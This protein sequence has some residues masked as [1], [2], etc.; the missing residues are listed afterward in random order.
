[1]R[2]DARVTSAA[3]SDPAVTPRDVAEARERIRASVRETP[4]LPSNVIAERAG[5]PVAL[6]LENLQRTGS[7][8]IRGAMN[9]I[10]A[11]D[12]REGV[13]A[14]S[15]GNHAQGVAYAA[16][17]YGIPS[18][19]VM[20]GEAPLAK[21]AATRDYG[22]EVI[23]VDGPLSTAIEHARTLAAERGLTFVPPFDHPAIVAGQGTL[24]LEILQ[25]VPDADT[26]VVPAGGGGLLAGIAAAVKPEHPHVRIVGVQ[27]VAM[28][29]VV[30]SLQAGKP[31]EMPAARTVAD[32]VAVA[33]PSALTL[34]LIQRYVDDVVTVSEDLIAQA[35]VLL[36]ERARV[37]AEGAGALATAAL[38][39]GLV[40]REGRGGDGTTVAIVSG[41]NIDINQLGRIVTRGLVHVGRHRTLT[42]AA[43]N[44]PGELVLISG[45]L[46]AARA[47]ILEVTH[48]LVTADL[49]VG[50][51]RLTFRLELAGPGAY[52][53]V[54]EALL[55][56]G[57]VRGTETDLCTPAAAAMHP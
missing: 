12:T 7:F 36:I 3:E 34:D 44:V 41:G 40:S 9:M 53:D 50:V 16:A 13:V 26:I 43:A 42:V 21:Q 46:A 6:K 32:G 54:L 49:P 35:I 11:L 5:A 48:E 45:G 28:P 29:G 27:S 22:A 37:V 52:E 10:S 57:L 30:R 18:I 51:A 47:N 24:G 31:L 23:L 20:P 8:K 1:V 19:V 17:E 25:Q 33:G 2:D 39:G 14:A 56:R 15:A 55:E 38:I 4:V